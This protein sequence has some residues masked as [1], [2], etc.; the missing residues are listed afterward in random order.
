M[1]SFPNHIAII[2]DGNRRY[3]ERRGLP[4]LEGHRAGVKTMVSTAEYLGKHHLKY[5]TV[6]GFSTENWSRPPDELEGLFHLFTETLNRESPELNKRNV[7][8]HHL[9]RL[10]ELPSDVQGAINRAVELTKNNTAMTLSF[11]VNYGGRAEIIDA[12]NRL[13]NRPIKKIDEKAFN[14]S[15]YTDGIPDVDLMIRTGGEVRLSN[16]LLWQVAYSEFYFTPV[17]WPDFD[18]KELEKALQVYSE[19]Q[20][21]FGG[22]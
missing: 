22:D 6:Y 9:G 17:L 1:D 16:F 15:L 21:R 20:R 14:C 5:L 19:R 10:N 11:A 4:P 13:I 18:T 8:L 3:A 2:M 7:K 12:V